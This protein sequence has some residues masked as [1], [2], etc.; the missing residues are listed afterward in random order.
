MAVDV[1]DFE[2]LSPKEAEKKL[3]KRI[4][5]LEKGAETVKKAVK[6]KKGRARVTE[7]G[8]DTVRDNIY[9]EVYDSDARLRTGR[10]KG[11]LT[12]YESRLEILNMETG[13]QTL[14]RTRTADAT[15]MA[16]GI[17]IGMATQAGY[18][19]MN[20][21]SERTGDAI[22]E[23]RIKNTVKMAGNIAGVSYGIKSAI[24][25]AGALG[26]LGFLAAYTTSEI[27][28]ANNA[29]RTREINNRKISYTSGLKG[30]MSYGG[31]R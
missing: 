5:A 4:A 29:S 19:Y 17:T 28:K 11:I 18:S 26:G 16:F 22:A 2:F 3:E 13:A 31:S 23:R 10:V 30:V 24:G 9:G 12:K 21:I 14:K 27:I 6:G 25:A 15:R 7:L 1:K 8:L 20:S